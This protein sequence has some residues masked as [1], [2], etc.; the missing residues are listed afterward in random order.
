MK[1]I[2]LNTNDNNTLFGTIIE[3]KSQP[4]AI[5]YIVHGMC[6]HKERYYEFLKYLSKNGYISIIFDLRG[7]GQNVEKENLGYFGDKDALIHDVD[8]VI[9][10]IKRE[11]PN[12]KIILFS[13]SMG[14]LIVRNYIQNNDD[15]IDKLIICGPPTIN[16]LS[17]FG[18]LLATIIGKF[19]GQHYRSK[20]I[21]SLSIGSYNKGF[22][23]PNAWLVTKDSVIDEYNNDELCGFIFTINGFKSLFYMLKKVYIPKYYKCNNKSLPIL[24]IGGSDDPV[25]VS[26]KKF[27]HLYKFLGKVGYENIESKLFDGMRHEILNEESKEKVYKKIIKYVK[28]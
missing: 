23:K 5:I 9:D 1:E 15:K 8:I 21:N 19:K 22:D 10:Y 25:I 16:R 18:T 4:K 7:H 17:S 2:K 6:E 27:D 14:S 26:K 12:L 11:Y 13:H 24:I 3:P 28:K 20:F